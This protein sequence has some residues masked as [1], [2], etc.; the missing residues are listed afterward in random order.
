MKVI[1]THRSPDFDAFASCVAAKKLFPEHLIVLPGNPARNLSEFLKIY[2][3]RFEFLWEHE[4]DGEVSDLVIVD[5]SSLDR[6]PERI[7]ERI[8]D[9]KI[10]VFDHHVD[11]KSLDGVVD[12]VGATIT[13][14]VERLRKEGIS[15]D[16]TEATL[17]MIALYDDTGNLLFSSTTPRDLEVAK[18]LLESGAKLDEVA[19]YTKEELTPQ[20]M[21]ILDRLLENAREYEVNGVPVT[22]SMAEYEGF[23]G[24][25]GLVVSKA[26][27]MS[28]S[29]TFIAIV[30]M[31]KKV[32]VVG[33]TSSPDVDLG[34]LMRSLGGG[35][36]TR[37]ASA[38]IVGREPEEVLSEILNRLHDHVVP[39]LRARDIM[40]SPVKV[41][42]ADMTIKEVNRLME[43][44]GHNGFPVVEGNKL[45]GIVTKK[46]VDKAMN[47]NLGDRPVKSIMTPNLVVATPDTP[48]TKLRELMVENAIGRIPILENGILVGIVT[49]SDVLRAIFG[50]PFKKYVKPVFRKNGQIFRNVTDLLIKHVKPRL[51]NLFRLLGKFGDE[52]NMPVYVV[53]GFVRDLLLG[54]ENLDID[55]VVEGNAMEF[56]EYAKKFL[57]AK[58]V[59]HEKFMTA[60]LFLKE[61][62]RIDVATAR[63]EYYESPARLP[64]VEMSTIKKDLYR[65]DFTIN[66]MAIKLNPGDFGLLV[67]FF[68]GYRDLKEGIIRVLHTLSF[69]DDPTRILRAIRFEQRFDFHI[70]ETTER[71]L[72][73]AVEEG[74]L[75]KTTGA[76]IR[77]E[78]EKILEEKNP[79]KSIRRMAEFD[80]IKHLFPKTYYTPVM[81][82]KMENLFRNIP[83]V[84]ENFGEVNKFYAVLHVFLEFYD[85]EGWEKVKKRYSL[86]K[87]LI[88]EVKHVE[89][90]AQAL[91]EM[92]KEGVPTSFIYP[93]VKGVSNETICHF[94]AYLEGEEEEKFKA[95]LL[96]IRD[97]KLEK[98][99]GNYLIEKGIKSGKIIG[100]VLEKILMKKLDGD[101]RDEE[102]IL[103]EILASLETEG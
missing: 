19:L 25:L 10:T 38:T 98:I 23:V 33:R 28:G 15:I 81:D 50:K 73:Q 55:I 69:V 62:L 65:R 46:A 49:R 6:I 94:L 59:K 27:E 75:E 91:L 80:V 48:V 60:S 16:A 18:F 20:Q 26:W 86:K 51:L 7:R 102:E 43:Q 87:N 47:H 77:Q 2:S 71:L 103:E 52:V 61:G 100:E 64:D 37:A 45:V 35:G 53:G 70:E 84:E 83:W 90:S 36:H 3:D 8:R 5:T 97:T 12:R 1:T 63:M 68:G 42:L 79:L 14:L 11:E 31:G 9:A 95:H 74:Y 40:S 4:F 13:L 56:A 92:L 34:S 32:Y 29:E 89:K 21:E 93:L 85:E 99:D 30:K 57:P 67:D 76:R 72:R 101:T 39:V 82:R 78:I 54:I 24:G 17:F 44:T 58:L 96:K 22:I 41:V 66:A 88:N